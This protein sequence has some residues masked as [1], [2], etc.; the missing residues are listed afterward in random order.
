MGADIVLCIKPIDTSVKCVPIA[1]ANQAAVM[2]NDLLTNTKPKVNDTTTYDNK[3]K[4]VP[5]YLFQPVVVTKDNYK[6]ILIDSGY[7]KAS[8]LG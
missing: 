3:V 1:L 7:Y 4:V 2:A 5:S 6:E 8:D